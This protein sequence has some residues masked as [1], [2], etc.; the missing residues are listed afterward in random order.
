MS[1]AQ[2]KA[3]KNYDE[4]NPVITFR[5]GKE[6][7][8]ILKENAKLAGKSDR[9]YCKEILNQHLNKRN[10]EDNSWIDRE[11]YD[12]LMKYSEVVELP[13]KEIIKESIIEYLD[14]KGSKIKRLFGFK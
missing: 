11:T 1:Q 9:E 8:I 6:N 7:Y 10:E 2:E 5:I 12:R 14:R 3:Q 13:V 4:K